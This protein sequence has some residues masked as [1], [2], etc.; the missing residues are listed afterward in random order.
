MLRHTISEPFEYQ[1][2]LLFELH[3]VWIVILTWVL[4]KAYTQQHQLF[5][6]K[7]YTT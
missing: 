3:V 5:R 4:Y 6:Y 7:M 1:N 2:C